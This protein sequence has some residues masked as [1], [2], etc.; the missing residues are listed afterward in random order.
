MNRYRVSVEVTAD[1]EKTAIEEAKSQL[2]IGSNNATVE[3]L[4]GL[5]YI[6]SMMPP[7]VEP[8]NA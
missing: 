3:F 6:E 5:E 4:I 2:V 7:K 8:T 1:N